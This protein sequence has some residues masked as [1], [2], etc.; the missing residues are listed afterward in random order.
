MR[1]IHCITYRR[2]GFIREMR[3]KGYDVVWS[4][5]FFAVGPAAL[6]ASPKQA[7]DIGG[8]NG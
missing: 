8:G 2:L 1:R 6:S 7:I 5:A 3:L 4:D